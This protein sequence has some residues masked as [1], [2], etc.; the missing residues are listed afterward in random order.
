MEPN[1][2]TERRFKSE[3]VVVSFVKRMGVS[4]NQL[5]VVE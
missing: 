3:G 4:V 1:D 5:Q 2:K